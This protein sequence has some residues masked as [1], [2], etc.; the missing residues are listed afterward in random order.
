MY[1]GLRVRREDSP[2]CLG[3]TTHLVS[4]YVEYRE[5]EEGDIKL[6]KVERWGGN[7][8]GSLSKMT[9]L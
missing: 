8:R 2:S 7:N 4:L 3:E 9:L 6:G 5:W 1:K